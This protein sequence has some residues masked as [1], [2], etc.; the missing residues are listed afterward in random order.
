MPSPES[1]PV[2]AARRAAAPPDDP[3]RPARQPER[4]AGLEAE[5]DGL[6]VQVSE[7]R[8]DVR[9]LRSEIQTATRHLL[10]AQLA[11]VALALILL[12]GLVGVSTTIR[13]DSGSVVV[14]GASSA[15]DLP[16]ADPLD[17]S[18]DAEAA[19]RAGGDPPILDGLAA[20]E[21]AAP[22]P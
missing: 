3:P 18:L 13:S 5:V 2:P 21:T 14:G 9:A 4:L 15:L 19:L 20:G 17:D 10:L 8:D 16:S 7:L 22:V 12:A 6:R 11:V 1:V